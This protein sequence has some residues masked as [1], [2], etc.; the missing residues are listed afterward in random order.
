MVRVENVMT[1][2]TITHEKYHEL[3]DQLSKISYLRNPELFKCYLRC[4]PSTS[5]H[6]RDGIGAIDLTFENE[7]DRIWFML[8]WL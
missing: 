4:Y 3:Y 8:K 1:V 6:R 2:V 5:K 7:Q